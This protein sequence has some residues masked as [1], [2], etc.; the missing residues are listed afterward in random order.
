M[1]AVAENVIVTGLTAQVAF[2][3][4]VVANP[5]VAYAPTMIRLI[6][7]PKI[8]CGRYRLIG[9]SNGKALGRFL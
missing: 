6:E 2:G 3:C 4:E 7:R 5:T 1:P 8:R 9:D